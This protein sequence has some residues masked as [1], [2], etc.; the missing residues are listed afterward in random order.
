MIRGLV[1]A[2]L[3]L[4]LGLKYSTNALWSSDLSDSISSYWKGMFGGF[5]V[6]L[7]NLGNKEPYFNRLIRI[8]NTAAYESKTFA[9]ISGCGNGLFSAIKEGLSW[10]WA[11]QHS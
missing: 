10:R 4:K 5:I 7:G 1:L 2:A 3:S 11:A 9:K 6:C 8:I